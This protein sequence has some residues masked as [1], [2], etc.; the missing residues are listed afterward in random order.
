MEQIS[1]AFDRQQRSEY[2]SAAVDSDTIDDA[3]F[4]ITSVS[5]NIM[6]SNWTSQASTVNWR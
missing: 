2:V 5:S 1:V 3:E 6:G 4:S